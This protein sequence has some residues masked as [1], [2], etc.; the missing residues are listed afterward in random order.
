MVPNNTRA[1]VLNDDRIPLNSVIWKKAVKRTLCKTRCVHCKNGYL[2]ECGTICPFCNGDGKIPPAETLEYYDIAFYDSAGRQY[3]VPAV[4]VN[5]HHIKRTF[6]QVPFSRVNVLKRDGYRC[7][8]CGKKLSPAVLTMDH[9][10]PRSMWAGND[11]PTNWHNI[12]TA[13]KRCN[14]KKDNRTPEQAGM[15]LRKKVKGRYV[16][17]KRPKAITPTQMIMGI[18]CDYYPEEWQPYVEPFLRQRD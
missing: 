6:K 16:E 3:Y 15:T 2:V 9:V 17:Y 7:Q 18:N 4:I 8:Y 10:V 14:M 13:C 11:T 12:V 5:R 1:L